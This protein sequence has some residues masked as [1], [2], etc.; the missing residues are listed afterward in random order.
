MTTVQP[1]IRGMCSVGSRMLAV[2][3]V[4]R[5]VHVLTLFFVLSSRLSPLQVLRKGSALKRSVKEGKAE[6][7]RHREHQRSGMLQQ[8]SGSSMRQQGSGDARHSIPDN[9]AVR[10]R[11]RPLEAMQEHGE[12]RDGATSTELVSVPE[13]L[14]R[15][16]L[17]AWC[18]SSIPQPEALRPQP[19]LYRGPQA[20]RRRCRYRCLPISSR[21]RTTAEKEA[22]P[23]AV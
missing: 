20:P 22:M 12:A 8:R 7:A 23:R 17:A 16:I 4:G 19:Q 21:L 9:P 15:E 5:T 2:Q 14:W 6:Y 3:I 18:C 1:T 11:R 13:H 10:Q